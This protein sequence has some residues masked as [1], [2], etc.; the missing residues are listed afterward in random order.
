MTQLGTDIN[1]AKLILESGGLV[2][3]PTETVYGLAGN[4]LDLE[5]LTRIFEAKNRPFFDPLILHVGAIEQIQSLVTEVPV[6]LAKLMEA[7]WPGPLTVLLPKSDR[8]P[9]LVTSGLPRVAIRIP[10]QPLT[11][12]LLHQ[13]DFPLAAPSANP[14][15]YVSPTRAHHV[16]DQLKDRVEYI[17]DGGPCEIGVEST[18]VGMEGHEVVVYRKGGLS[19]E[20]IEKVAGPVRL[21]TVSSSQPEAPGMLI[22]H[23]A[24]RIPVQLA[25]EWAGPWDHR[26]GYLGWQYPHP[27][28][29]LSN[30]QILSPEGSLSEAAYHLFDYLRQMDQ[31]EVEVI[32]T[33]WLPD[34]GLG[35]AINDKLKRATASR[36]PEI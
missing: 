26:V 9:D 30:Q 36:Y 8:V 16:A 24:P 17:L 1:Q 21:N 15:G 32:L 14:F 34:E 33:E 31:W 35:R 18:I 28:I 5:A 4:A 11:L 27:L 22:K 3:I 6:A 23:Y 29:P 13:L 2:A 12:D 10:N 20:E 7:F 19:V 25:S